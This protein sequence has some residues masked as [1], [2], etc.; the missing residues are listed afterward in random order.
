MFE[1]IRHYCL[2]LY[3][4]AKPR[5]GEAT[6]VFLLFLIIRGQASKLRGTYFNW[7]YYY[8]W[9]QWQPLE[10]LNRKLWNLAH[11][12]GTVPWSNSQPPAGQIW[13][14][15]YTRNFWSACPIIKNEVWIP[16]IKQSSTHTNFWL[17]RFPTI[18]GQPTPPT[19]FVPFSSKNDQICS[20]DQASQ[21]LW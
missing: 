7:Y 21:K 5:S 9:C 16:W 19:I 11:S 2:Q 12:L 15:V 17:Y 18:S 8:S 6:L 4:E 13:S 10:A 14:C 1:G 20:S 3:S